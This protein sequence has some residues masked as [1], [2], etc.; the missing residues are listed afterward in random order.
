MTI[1]NRIQMVVCFEMVQAHVNL[2]IFWFLKSGHCI[3]HSSIPLTYLF[4]KE[5]SYY[6][7][8]IDSNKKRHLHWWRQNKLRIVQPI[9]K[10]FREPNQ[11]IV[12]IIDSQHPFQ[13]YDNNQLLQLTHDH[14]LLICFVTEITKNHKPI[15]FSSF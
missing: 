11:E 5:F 2:K 6:T 13:T 15:Y 4:K 10:L 8:S 1:N 3:S 14:L 9:L 12:W 7:H